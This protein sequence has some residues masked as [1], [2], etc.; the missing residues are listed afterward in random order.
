MMTSYSQLLIAGDAIGDLI[1]HE[2]AEQRAR[3]RVVQ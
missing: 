2:A 1:F 3:R